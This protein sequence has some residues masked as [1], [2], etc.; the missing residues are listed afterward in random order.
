[1]KRFDLWLPNELYDRVKLMKHSLGYKSVTEV[2]IDLI[3]R[4]YLQK[5]GA[6]YKKQDREE[7]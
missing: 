7:F 5:L 1:M 6:D 2:L 3:E 4:G